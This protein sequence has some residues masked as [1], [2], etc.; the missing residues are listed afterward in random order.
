MD[1][2]AFIA[3][4]APA[5]R[6][7]AQRTGMSYELMLAQTAQETGWGQKTLPNTNNLFNIKADSSWHGVSAEF[8]VP[9]YLNGQLVYVKAQFR[10]YASYEEAFQDR[11][12]FLQRNPRY[13]ALF[14]P[15]NLGNFSNEATV[16]QRAG[17]A[18]D[19][20][21]AQNLA[22]V[23]S[24]KTMQRA[25]KMI[26]TNGGLDVNRPLYTDP[27]NLTLSQLEQRGYGPTGW[28][29]GTLIPE[30]VGYSKWTLNQDG[31][32]FV[33]VWEHEQD[34]K[35]DLGPANKIYQF[36]K[37]FNLKSR[38]EL[39][40]TGTRYKDVV[41]A[42]EDIFLNADGDLVL[43]SKNGNT[44]FGT[45]IVG[46]SS[47]Q[48]YSFIDRTLCTDGSGIKRVSRILCKRGEC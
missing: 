6:A 39:D 41:G 28:K 19:P 34:S 17:Y 12:A 18:T 11:V 46:D 45:V 14:R 9:E 38:I 3:L 26:I 47:G 42:L 33:E 22:N 7:V 8:V 48:H 32:L 13:V 16:L 2:T 36:D 4:I 1:K 15:E 37:Q 30:N 5:A 44:W 31:F 43:Q 27:S 29:L 10:V 24:G 40:S 21:Y 35:G 20:G 23:F 25:L